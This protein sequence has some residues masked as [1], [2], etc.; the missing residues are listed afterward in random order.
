MR[1]LRGGV[2][3]RARAKITSHFKRRYIQPASVTKAR[4]MPDIPVLSRLARPAPQRLKSV[5]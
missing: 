4:N 3:L 2:V 1:L 5:N